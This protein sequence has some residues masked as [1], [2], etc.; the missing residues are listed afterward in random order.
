VVEVLKSGLQDRNSHD[1]RRRAGG[2]LGEQAAGVANDC[3]GGGGGI[4][5]KWGPREK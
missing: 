1:Q 5:V 4:E 3:G 2:W